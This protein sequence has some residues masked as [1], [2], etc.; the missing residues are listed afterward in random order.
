LQKTQ[1][2]LLLLLF[3]PDT[4]AFVTADWAELKH[5]AAAAS[6]VVDTVIA[7]DFTTTRALVRDFGVAMTRT[8]QRAIG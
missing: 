5:F 8:D 1:E 4:H 3:G 6:K 2:S 7:H